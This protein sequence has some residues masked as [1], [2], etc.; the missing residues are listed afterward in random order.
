PLEDVEGLPCW[1]AEP[2]WTQVRDADRVRGT[3]LESFWAPSADA[4]TL[5]L[6]AGRDF[7]RVIF[8]ISLGAVPYLCRELIDAS[9][10]WRAMTE[11]VGTVPT[12]AFQVWLT[13]PRGGPARPGPLSN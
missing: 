7:D 11:H 1:P 5:T 2:R 12:Q 3:N 6:A 10:R 8:G 4:A 13:P 9:D